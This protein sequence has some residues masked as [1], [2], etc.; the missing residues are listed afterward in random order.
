MPSGYKVGQ[1]TQAPRFERLERVN[2]WQ[3]DEVVLACRRLRELVAGNTIHDWAP[4]RG[5][6]RVER[7]VIVLR[8]LVKRTSTRATAACMVRS[9]CCNPC[10]GSSVSRPTTRS[11][12]YPA[13]FVLSQQNGGVR[14]ARFVHA[15]VAL[16]VPGLVLFS[17]SA[18]W[19]GSIR[20]V[21]GSP[22]GSPRVRFVPRSCVA[23]LA[24]TR[25]PA[26]WSLCRPIRCR[27]RWARRRS[28]GR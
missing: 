20:R 21:P 22:R 16:R 10:S 13:G 17:C 11:P 25:E 9:C 5:R 7:G 4:R 6:S 8:L 27:G 24:A 2:T 19:R 26:G 15:V 3:S 28:R 18:S 12:L 1:E 23:G 14:P